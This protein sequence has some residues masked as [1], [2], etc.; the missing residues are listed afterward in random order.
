MNTPL[1]TWG[2]IVALF[3]IILVVRFCQTMK[4]NHKTRR[5]VITIGSEREELFIPGDPDP[6]KAELNDGKDLEDI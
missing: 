6:R 3:F 1:I 4:H 2:C 5:H